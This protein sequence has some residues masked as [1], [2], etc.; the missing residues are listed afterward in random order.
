MMVHVGVQTKPILVKQTDIWQIGLEASF[1]K[2]SH[3]KH[4]SSCNACKHSTI[5]NFHI[6]SP[7]SNDID[8]KIKEAL[9]IKKHR[10]LL[11]NHLHQHGAS[12]F[13]MYFN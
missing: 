12:F 1:R 2:F 6:L 11:I 5:E 4:I 10:P 13:L 9:Y 3:F 7:G 8:I